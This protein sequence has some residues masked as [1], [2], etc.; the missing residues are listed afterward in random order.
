[1]IF[2]VFIG[3][4]M[5]KNKINFL[6]SIHKESEDKDND[7]LIIINKENPYIKILLSEQVLHHIATKVRSSIMIGDSLNKIKMRNILNNLS[8]CLSPWNC[9][10]G[11]PTMRFLKKILVII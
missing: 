10:N 7:N 1:M 3:K 6:Q 8:T 11:I 4:W 2:L 5:E 9:P